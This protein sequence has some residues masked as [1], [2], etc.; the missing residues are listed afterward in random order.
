MHQRRGHEFLRKLLEDS[1]VWHHFYE[2]SEH[3]MT[4]EVAAKQ[5]GV[6]PEKIIKT[7]VVVSEK[8]EPFI[9]IIPGNKKLD[10]N[11]LSIIIGSRVR[12]AKAREVEKITGYA[13]GALPPVGHGITTYV[14]KSVLEHERVV[15]GGGSTHA[16]VEIET[17][18]LIRLTKALV[19]DITE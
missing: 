1:G 10:L 5:L 2:F 7:L 15:G 4:V 3:T 18:D 17:K 14:D 19:R 11:R 6:G 13:V 12:M 16:L 8:N 9:A